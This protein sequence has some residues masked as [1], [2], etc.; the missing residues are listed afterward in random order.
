[1]I[2]WTF[3]S[4]LAG[5]FYLI[6]SERYRSGL[7]A[8]EAR[9][10]RVGQPE[11]LREM[12]KGFEFW[13]LALGVGWGVVDG[14]NLMPWVKITKVNSDVIAAS[15]QPLL[16]CFE[17]VI[18]QGYASVCPSIREK[19]WLSHWRCYCSFAT[20]L[21]LWTTLHRNP[22]HCHYPPRDKK[23]LRAYVCF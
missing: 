5:F 20:V 7:R 12:R 23:G 4:S 17:K 16:I 15:C 8:G 10:S 11:E 21:H 22:R 1:M 3:S 13:P 6:L 14:N 19:K 18:C 9:A 2:V